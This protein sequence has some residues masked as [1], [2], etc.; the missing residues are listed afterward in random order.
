[1]RRKIGR[2]GFSR[3]N[4]NLNFVGSVTTQLTRCFVMLRRN[5]LSNRFCEARETRPLALTDTM[6]LGT[7]FRNSSTSAIFRHSIF[8][9]CGTSPTCLDAMSKRRSARRTGISCV[10]INLISSTYRAYTTPGSFSRS[11]RNKKH[12]ARNAEASGPCG[13]PCP[14]VTP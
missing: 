7:F 9:A 11:K 10:A 4:A 2:L 6:L 5:I 1:M 12:Y 8:C 14:S 13:I 3:N